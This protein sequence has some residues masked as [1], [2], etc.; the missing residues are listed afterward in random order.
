MKLCFRNETFTLRVDGKIV[1]LYAGAD[2]EIEFT[3]IP[4][5]R[6]WLVDELERV[7]KGGE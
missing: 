2:I 5:R 1:K 6:Q 7:E 3:D 4:D